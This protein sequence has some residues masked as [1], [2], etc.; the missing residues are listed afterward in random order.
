MPVIVPRID[1]GSIAPQLSGAPRTSSP[2]T[3]EG[4][5]GNIGAALQN[6]GG[7][8][9]DIAYREQQKTDAAQA[10]QSR[11]A[12]SQFESSQFDPNNTEG[13]YSYKGANALQAPGVVQKRMD[14]FASKY[15]QGL[16]N[17]NQQAQ[18]DQL[19][20]DHRLQLTDRTNR[21]ALGEH[22]K[23][24]QESY[25]GAV[26]S[27]LSAVTSKATAGDMAGASLAAKDGVQSIMEYGQANGQPKEFVDYSIDKFLKTAQAATQAANK[28]NAEA[29]ILQ[30]PDGALSDFSAR[31]GLG[32]YSD[33][34][35]AVSGD[36]NASRGIR[37]N[38]PGNLQKTDVQWQGKV[39][40]TDPR[41][42][43]FATP[44]AGIR[45]LAL[46][47]QH[48]QA[49]GAQSV[50]DLIG[51]WS[52]VKENGPEV[53]QAYIDNV[54]KSMGVS[55]TDNINLQD[56]A[57]L[58]AFTQA[59]INQE[60]GGNPY[61][62]EQVTTGVQAALGKAKLRETHPPVAT[63]GSGLVV[64][65]DGSNAPITGLRAS[66][67][68]MI[69]AL[70]TASTVDLYNRARA[71]VNRNQ[72][73]FQGS[74]AQREKD[75]TAAFKTGQG[76]AQPLTLADYTRAYGDKEGMQRYGAYQ[77][78]QQLGH[79][80]SAV[81]TLTPQ[82]MQ[83]LAST[84]APAPGENFAVKQQDHN[85]L[86]TAMKQTLEARQKDPVA[87]AVSANIGGFKP[88]DTTAPDKMAASIAARVGPSAAISQQYQTPYRLL[89][90]DEGTKLSTSVNAMPAPDKANFL[91]ALS[92]QL[93]PADYAQ[94]I[95]TIKKDSPTTAIAGRIMGAGRAAQVGTKGSLWW[96]SPVEMDAATTAQ[97]MLAG[98]ALLNPSKADKDANGSPKF[99]MPTD[100]ATNGLR[101]TWNDIVGDAF[102]GDGPGEMQAYQA[103]RSMYAGLASKAGRVD[104]VLDSDIATKATRA[105]IGNV[106]EWNGKNVIPPYGMDFNAFKDQVNHQWQAVRSSV[107]GADQQDADSYD[108][109]R[110]G[111]GVYAVSNGQAPLRDKEGKPVILR[112]SPTDPSVSDAAQAKDTKP[113]P[114]ASR[115]KVTF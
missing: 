108:L 7:V 57:Q 10:N 60:N 79:D 81:A 74:I 50:T 48:L 100:S 113:Y 89:T 42:E 96:K 62:P 52:P 2:V 25:E 45:A 44:E 35:R 78:D 76:V 73:S 15:R 59:V 84:R 27:A 77:A 29:Y 72:V 17:A 86:V 106:D 61:T 43:A 97:T 28:A 115:M 94:V 46:N 95:S 110:I 40:S 49:N 55:P 51:K 69:D 85:S 21:Y 22:D 6:A 70:D 107:P 23:F 91:G 9:S 54:S 111:D 1:Q 63:N 30:N 13:V 90:E 37:N 58:Q 102:R 88:M 103:Y 93:N 32:Q 34:S 24:Q 99:A 33:S 80:L 56:P 3:A 39:D 66:G 83:D 112:V 18:F 5:G 4:M 14:E 36:P 75:D 87:W 11:I 64:P 8:L 71:E 82:Q 109:D 19:Y 53:T 38:N 20:A 67:N 12:L 104:G 65:G 47:A 26:G 101:G 105:T 41:Y 114:F 68:P 31:L 98:D 16:T 92:T